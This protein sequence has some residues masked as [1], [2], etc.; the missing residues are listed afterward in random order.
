MIAL[1]ERWRRRRPCNWRKPAK[2][3]VSR[4]YIIQWRPPV[5]NPLLCRARA[6]T[7]AMILRTFE[8]EIRLRCRTAHAKCLCKK[9]STLRV[10]S[11]QTTTR[12]FL[13]IRGWLCFAAECMRANDSLRP[14]AILKVVTCWER[15]SGVRRVCYE[16]STKYC[17]MNW[18]KCGNISHLSTLITPKRICF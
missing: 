17:Y 18:F 1:V 4:T 16:D 9:V 13:T 2:L 11:G 15:K 6:R 5:Q 12:R 10:N 3:C 14:P 8:G 7:Q